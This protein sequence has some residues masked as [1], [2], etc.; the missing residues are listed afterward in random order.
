[1]KRLN[2]NRR[3]VKTA[4]SGNAII[5]LIAKADNVTRSDLKEISIKSESNL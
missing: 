5:Q 2:L 1:M 3:M 4:A